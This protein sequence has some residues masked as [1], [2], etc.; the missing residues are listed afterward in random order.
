[1]NYN[2]AIIFYSKNENLNCGKLVYICKKEKE[3]AKNIWCL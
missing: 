3:Y 2:R 1:M